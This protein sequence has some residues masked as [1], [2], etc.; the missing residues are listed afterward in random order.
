[1]LDFSSVYVNA[2]S[3]LTVINGESNVLSGRAAVCKCISCSYC[4]F[5]IGGISMLVGGSYSAVGS[6][7]TAC[8]LQNF[9][10][11]CTSIFLLFVW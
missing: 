4:A 2:C 3:K 1:M 6:D 9:F 7:I 5:L 10:A 11:I 8:V